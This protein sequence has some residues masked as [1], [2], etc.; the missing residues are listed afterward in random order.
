M[1]ALFCVPWA[2]NAQESIPYTEGFENMS[3]ASDLTAA[4]WISSA[5]AS[6]CF[7]AIETSPTNV[8]T[9]SKAL[10]ID[11]YS[12]SSSSTTFIVG[13]PT[14]DV[15]INTFANHIF[16]QG[17]EYHSRCRLSDRCQRCQHIC[18][19]GIIQQL[20]ELYNRDQGIRPSPIRSC[21]Y[22]HQVHWLLPLLY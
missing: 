20:F 18:A 1:F 6:A 2:A 12:A 16:V 9:G 19:I 10:N 15:P 17:Y 8:H 13:L 4:G 11:S 14:V 5:S 7:L 22:R 21:P 3:S